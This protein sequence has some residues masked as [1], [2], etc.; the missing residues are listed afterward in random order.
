MT[1]MSEIDRLI[2]IE[3]IKRLKARR[4]RAVDT[5]DWDTYLALHAPD[6]QSRNDGFDHWKSAAEMIAN[7]RQLLGPDKISVHHSHTPE[8]DFTSPTHA[9]G[10]WAMED[11]IFWTEDGADQWLH[12]FGFYHETY[13]KRSGQW[14]FTSRQ[15]KRTKVVTSTIPAEGPASDI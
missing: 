3:D 5:K 2:A 14:L 6:H 7:V 11:N 9:K 4:D 10:I 12:G 13:E 8:I 1:D 15:L